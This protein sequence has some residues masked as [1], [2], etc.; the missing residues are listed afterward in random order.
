MLKDNIVR[1]GDIKCTARTD[2]SENWALCDG[3]VIQAEADSEIVNVLGNN[4]SGL[5]LSEMNNAKWIES[6]FTNDSYGGRE[7]RG[8]FN[9]NG[10]L[11]YT[12][13]KKAKYY[14]SSTKS[15]VSLTNLENSISSTNY[16]IL[17]MGY[18]NGYYI[19]LQ[20]RYHDSNTTLWY[21]TNLFGSFT[22]GRS[23]SNDGMG[24]YYKDGYWIVQTT[25]TIYFSTSLTGDWSY[26]WA[27]GFSD[28]QDINSKS[29]VMSPELVIIGS[30]LYK[31]VAMGTA[32]KTIVY[33]CPWPL[34]TDD[35][36]TE[37]F[38]VTTSTV[39]STH[40]FCHL[41]LYKNNFVIS[42]RTHTGYSCNMFSQSG[43]ALGTTNSI[44]HFIVIG[45]LVYGV[46]DTG[47]IL[48]ITNFSDVNVTDSTTLEYYDTGV[49]F[50]LTKY[51]NKRVCCVREHKGVQDLYNVNYFTSSVKLPSIKTDK[52]YNYIKI[53]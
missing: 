22:K 46:E 14:N 50:P 23:F 15:F 43:V 34:T 4:G 29:Y 36:W 10:Y 25:T 39:S 18:V 1:V 5:Q 27:S 20:G 40:E 44:K 32:D 2:E 48:I 31:C 16:Y 9:V 30:K 51:Q 11:V 47:R 13:A 17:W 35:D 21:S 3:S 7:A 24:V 37:E 45:D 33:S 26:K 41:D 38:T 42:Y 49:V 19:C 52:S 12:I 28:P 6:S 8:V 53:K